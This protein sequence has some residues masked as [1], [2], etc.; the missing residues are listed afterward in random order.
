[1]S[2]VN[3]TVNIKFQDEAVKKS[4]GQAQRSEV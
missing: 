1:M 2:I 4:G 3:W